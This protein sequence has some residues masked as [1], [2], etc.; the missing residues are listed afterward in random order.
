MSRINQGAIPNTII[1]GRTDV[2]AF[3]TPP[4]LWGGRELF[5]PVNSKLIQKNKTTIVL[6]AGV[7][8]GGRDIIVELGVAPPA[9]RGAYYD[10]DR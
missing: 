5:N 10:I 8:Y 3:P 6:R 7:P 9:G 1:E 2:C 4:L